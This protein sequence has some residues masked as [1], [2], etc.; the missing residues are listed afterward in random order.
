MKGIWVISVF[1]VIYALVR[2]VLFMPTYINHV[3]S[4]I[5]N[6]AVG[7]AA[8]FFLV[9]ALCCRCCGQTDK[10]GVYFRAT[11]FAVVVHVPLSLTLLRPGYFPEFF[12]KD[13]S[14]LKPWGEMVV[15]FGAVGL[16]TLWQNSRDRLTAITQKRLGLTLLIVIFT[17]VGSMGIC[18]GLNITAKHAYLPPMWLLSLVVIA[19]G[20]AMV[21][22]VQPK[23]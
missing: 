23:E 19:V 9:Y 12:T 15:L 22:K 4:F 14:T 6:K 20:F 10:A 5:L 21:A 18:R 1:S 13:G 11:F 3:P 8:S 16:A 7:M 2:Y 17:H